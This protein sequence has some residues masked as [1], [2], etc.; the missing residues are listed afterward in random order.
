MKMGDPGH[1]HIEGLAKT[2]QLP[3]I[4]GLDPDLISIQFSFLLGSSG[5]RPDSN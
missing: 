4:P 1:S 3:G 2:L 5:S